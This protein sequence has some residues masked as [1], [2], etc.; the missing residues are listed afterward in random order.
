MGE[1]LD[2]LRALGLDAITVLAVAA[3][4]V[5]WYTWRSERR[6]M[7]SVLRESNAHLAALRDSDRDRTRELVAMHEELRTLVGALMVEAAHARSSHRGAE[8]GR[9]APGPARGGQPS[10]G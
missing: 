3:L 9:G 2:L 5:V 6:D 4:G 7:L 10:E 1:L 8:G